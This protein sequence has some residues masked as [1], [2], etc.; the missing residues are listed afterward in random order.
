[1]TRKDYEAVAKILSNE[2]GNRCASR[3]ESVLEITVALADLFEA[4]NERFDRNKWLVACMPVGGLAADTV[5]VL[6]DLDFHLCA[7]VGAR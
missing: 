6:R 5:E 7:L 1:M 2:R 3:L 4:D